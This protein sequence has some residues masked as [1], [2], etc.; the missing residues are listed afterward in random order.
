[1]NHDCAKIYEELLT[2][3]E[4]YRM[5]LSTASEAAGKMSD[6]LELFNP[7]SEFNDFNPR[8]AADKFK[9]TAYECVLAELFAGRKIR[10]ETRQASKS[11]ANTAENPSPTEKNLVDFAQ[12]V[13]KT[14]A[15]CL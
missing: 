4:A 9:A 5:A 8:K 10:M 11:K 2:S 12:Y 3:G 13:K 15:N 14:E 6:A 7:L 1:M